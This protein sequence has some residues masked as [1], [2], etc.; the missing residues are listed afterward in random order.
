MAS[1]S[2]ANRGC[3]LYSSW[4]AFIGYLC[5][6]DKFWVKPKKCCDWLQTPNEST[7]TTGHV[8]EDVFYILVGVLLWMFVQ[9]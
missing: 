9:E 2:I 5:E 3:L 1:L 4:R 7:P 6:N 8:I